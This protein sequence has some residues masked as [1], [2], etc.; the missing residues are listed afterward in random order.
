M[1]PI[2][3]VKKEENVT[4]LTAS[5]KVGRG[6]P[7]TERFSLRERD[8]VIRVIARLFRTEE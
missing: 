2:D 7:G 8:L 6:I 1:D 3:Q 5:K 4:E